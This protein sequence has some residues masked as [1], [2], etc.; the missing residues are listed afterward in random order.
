M[1]QFEQLEIF[2]NVMIALSFLAVVFAIYG[3]FGSDLWLASTQWLLIAVVIGV[4]A[5]F[6][7]VHHKVK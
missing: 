2:S 5:V 3:Y 6:F 7:T 1:K 4:W